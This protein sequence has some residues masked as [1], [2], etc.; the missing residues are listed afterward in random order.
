MQS[1]G[2][3]TSAQVTA[4]E[5]FAP[6]DMRLDALGNAHVIFS[7]SGRWNFGLRAGLNW[8]EA[9]LLL[10]GFPG[11]YAMGNAPGASIA[12]GNDGRSH[13]VFVLGDSLWYFERSALGVVG[14]PQLVHTMGGMEGAPSIDVGPDGM[15][16]VAFQRRAGSSQELLHTMRVGSGW[17]IPV[18]AA[19]HVSPL[20]NLPKCVL[21]VGAGGSMVRIA[22]P[23]PIQAGGAGVWLATRAAGAWSTTAVLPCAAGPGQGGGGGGGGEHDPY[24]D[25]VRSQHAVG[26]DVPR[27]AASF[28]EHSG[29]LELRWSGMTWADADIAME[30]FEVSGRRVMSLDIR[31]VSGVARVPEA[32][33]LPAGVYFVQVSEAGQ[34]SPA[35]RL[36]KHRE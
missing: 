9:P 30:V 32:G 5:A 27:I 23:A 6:P 17:S 13:M 31:R 8:I 33:R 24:Y 28:H 35:T 11:G 14:P 22:Y 15:A 26:P 19:S 21:R 36:L 18:V 29:M 2:H 4:A 25:G 16:H 7:G 10:P 34:R 1:G 12:V 3:F 20:P